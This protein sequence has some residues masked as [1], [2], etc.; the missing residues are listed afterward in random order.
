MKK[1]AGYLFVFMFLFVAVVVSGCG[2][3]GGGSVVAPTTG[4]I[5]IRSN[6]PNTKFVLDGAHYTTDANGNYT[7]VASA[8]DHTFSCDPSMPFTNG[9][10]ASPT[11]ASL[12]VGGTQT[13]SCG[14]NIGNCTSA[15]CFNF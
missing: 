11:S 4:T 7:L 15:G 9:V 2:G 14:Y 8:G 3:G 5:N 1:L 13:F 6:V 10:T 12:A